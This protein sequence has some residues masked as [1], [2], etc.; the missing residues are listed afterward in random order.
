MTRGNDLRTALTKLL[1]EEE[2]G[3]LKAAFDVVGDI[4]IIEVDEELRKKEKVIA[5]TLLGLHKNLK[6]VCRKEG[7]HEGE[8]RT[9]KMKVLAGENRLETEHRENNCRFRVDVE[10]VYFSPRLS[11]ERKR[12][13]EEVKEGENVL[14]MFSGAGPYPIVIAK[15]SKAA[16]IVGIEKNPEGHKYALLNAKLNKTDN[17]TFYVGDVRD[18]AIRKK[19]DRVLMPLPKGGEDFLDVALKRVKPGGIVHFYD[20]LHINDFHLARLKVLRACKKAGIRFRT[21]ALRRCGQSAPRFFR[22]ILD[23]KVVEK[24]L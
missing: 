11:T 4:A 15:N 18:V 12:M 19:F 16:E 3:H 2:M 14:V 21:I 9:Q 20:F 5:Q 7:Q 6:V 10:K 22:V 24:S 1:T 23:F 17:V 13:A 8:F